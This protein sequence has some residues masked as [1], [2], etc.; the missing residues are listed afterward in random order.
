MFLFALDCRLPTTTAVSPNR[1]VNNR[2]Y[3]YEAFCNS[4][5]FALWRRYFRWVETDG[6]RIG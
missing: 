2:C 6:G 3:P 4:R 1:P 5:L